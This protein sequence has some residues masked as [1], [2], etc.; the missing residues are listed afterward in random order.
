MLTFTASGALM[1]HSH[2][3]PSS[4]SP[5]G[6]VERAAFADASTVTRRE[7]ILC[8]AIAFRRTALGRSTQ[9]RR[10]LYA[11]ARALRSI[12]VGPSGA[13][14]AACRPRSLFKGPWRAREAAGPDLRVGPGSTPLARPDLWQKPAGRTVADSLA[15]RRRGALRTRHAVGRVARALLEGVGGAGLAR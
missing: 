2:Q 1:I 5:S 14:L 12:L 11:V 4:K 6:L 3:L 9:R 10:T 13:Q 7:E 15:C 8:R